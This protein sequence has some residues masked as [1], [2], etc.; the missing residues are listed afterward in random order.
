MLHSCA[1]AHAEGL[2]VFTVSLLSKGQSISQGWKAQLVACSGNRETTTDAEREKYHLQ[3]NDRESLVA[4]FREIGERNI[5]VR[6]T[7]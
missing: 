6:R 2:D 3:G 5:T 1:L 7:R 4:A